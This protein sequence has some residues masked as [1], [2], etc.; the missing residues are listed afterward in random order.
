LLQ[1]KGID[2]RSKIKFENEE[3]SIEEVDWN[4][5]SNEDKVNILKSDDQNNDLDD[6]EI[7]LINSIRNSGMSPAE[8]LQYVTN[9]GI[10]HYIQNNQSNGYQFTVDQYSDEDLFKA[11][12]I[13]RMGDVTE[14]EAQE[15]L[16]KAQ[17]NETLFKK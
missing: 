4:T 9:D 15:A 5:L 16:E 2:D 1:L 10:N 14:E 13:S 17:S 11:D 12:F 3:G 6:S 7:Q 8:Y